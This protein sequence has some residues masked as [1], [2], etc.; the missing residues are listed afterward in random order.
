M[1]AKHL[2]LIPIGALALVMPAAADVIYSNLQN[3]SIPANFDGL[4]LDVN[5]GNSN[6]SMTSPVAGWD[7][8]AFYG[9]KN[10]ANSPGFQPVRTTTGNTSAIV[11]LAAGAGV[12]SGSTYSSF[13]W[14]HDANSG[15][16][17]VPGYGS[18]QMLTGAGGN[19]TA[20]TEGYLGFKLYTD[21]TYTAANYGWMRVVFT[22]NTGG[23]VI[24]DWA[25]DNT[26][27]AAINT[28]NVLQSA[29]ASSAQT[30]TLSSAS[31]SFSLG[32]AI[33]NTGGNTNSVVKTSAGTTTLTGTN[34]YTGA[35]TIQQGTLALGADG[36]IDNSTTL[37]VGDT[38]STGAVL[39]VSAISGGFTVGAGQTLKGIGTVNGAVT[40][41]GTHAPGNSAGLQTVTGD[42]SYGSASI[43]DWE[44]T[45]NTATQGTSPNFTFDQVD[46][47]G[48]S[49]TLSIAS[50]AKINLIVNNGVAFS[51]AFWNTNQSWNIF[52][53]VSTV[54]GNFLINN[55][56]ND[57]NST[58]YTALH[59]YGSF[60]MTGTTLTW[61]AVPE[62]SSALAAMLLGAGL[63]RR[64]RAGAS[65][66]R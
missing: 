18:S 61:T 3:L 42:L 2:H 30:V 39:D 52:T 10:V 34:T 8:N 17:Q 50:G 48:T 51:D 35:T 33:T 25:Y 57:M 26:G 40:I 1:K 20:G 28:G 7:I 27:G 29:A 54:A 14:D 66:L 58:A 63:L 55:I 49:D 53:N 24:K 47:T 4:Y 64:R 32:S 43:F 44:L 45:S 9:G 36:S 37:V 23:A 38:G 5:T 15:T 21:A 13:T 31:G 62:P 56:S 6:T 16:A 60:T 11:N 19:F 65:V 41:N 22:D 59:P 12:G 46:M